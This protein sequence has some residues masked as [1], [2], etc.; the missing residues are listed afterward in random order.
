MNILIIG[1]FYIE[2]FALHISETLEAMGHTVKKYE[3]GFYSNRLKGSFGQKFDKVCKNIYSL[4]DSISSIRSCRVNKLWH[5]TDSGHVDAVIVCHDFLW[6]KEVA[7]LKR[8]T[9][10]PVALWFPDALINIGRGFFMNADYDAIFFKDPYIVKMLNPVL[11]TP[12]YYLPECFNPNKHWL[13]PELIGSDS[14]YQCDIATA[15]NTHSYR[16]AFFKHLVGYNVK[17]WGNHPPS[18]L[19]GCQ[20]AK[21]HQGR[22][23]LDHEK[24]RAFRGAKIVINNLHFSEI[25]GVNVRT[26]EVAGAG[27]FQMVD[28]RPGLGQ[29]FEEDKELISFHNI[30]EMKEK[31]EYWLPRDEERLAVGDAAMTR[32]HSE[33]TYFHRLEL[34]LATLAG[35]EKGFPIRFKNYSD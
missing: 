3:P 15:G 34:L 19:Y 17:Q 22:Q 9:G 7:E 6:P 1:K 35:R 30:V 2:G 23:V 28:W 5:V 10:A 13:P 11:S 27:A 31:I 16:S 25:W 32:A 29:L 21:M 4:S 33:H 12:V 24:V 14:I 20:V 26:F 18:W 8:R